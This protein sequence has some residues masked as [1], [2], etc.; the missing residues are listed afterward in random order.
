MLQQSSLWARPLGSKPL[1]CLTQANPGPKVS[2]EEI[3]FSV[4][5]NTSGK[6][7][8]NKKKK[9]NGTDFRA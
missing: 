2:Y 5:R 6:K 7:I 9:I 8:N 3:A 4:R 1:L